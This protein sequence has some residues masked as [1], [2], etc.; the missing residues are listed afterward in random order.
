VYFDLDVPKGDYRIEFFANPSAADP[1]GN[2]E[3][4]VFA[5]ATT[6]AHTGSGIESFG[7]TFPGTVGDISTS[8]TTE[9]LAGP[10]YGASSEF[11]GAFTA[12]DICP[13][14]VVTTTADSGVSS[15]L[16]SCIIWANGNVGADTLSVPAGT[17]NLSIAGT[18]EDAATTGDLDITDDL[19]LNGA[20][21]ISTIIDGNA[22]DRVFDFIAG[23]SELSGV[24]VRN[25]NTNS[26]GGGILNHSNLTLSDLA[27]SGNNAN[28]GGGI[29]NLLGASLT[30]SN[31]TINGNTATSV[32]GG[33]RDRGTSVLTNVTLSG[34][35]ASEGGGMEIRDGTTM[36]NVTITANSAAD[37]GGLQTQGA[38][39][40]S[41]VKN[42]IIA[43]NLIG[44]DCLGGLTVLGNNLDSDG[45]CGFGL[46]D[47]APLL[48]PL[49][50]NGGPTFTHALL[51][52]SPAIDSGDS[53]V[54][55]SPTNDR[56]QR[57]F[58]R[59][60]GA[61]CDIGAYEADSAPPT[62]TKAAFWT[63][64]T[65]IP[66]GSTIPSGVEFKY[67]LYVNNLSVAQ[68]DVT[69]RD[70]LDPAFQYQVGTIQV[71]NSVAECAGAVCTPAEEQTIFTAVD[72]AAF[73]T[74][75]ADGDV[76]G[77]TGASTSVDAGNG[78]VANLQL[79]INGGAVWAILFSAKMP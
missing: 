34:N 72:G 63:D 29:D 11:S 17:Y 42:T 15:T 33:F 32:G 56:D 60:V 26:T 57:G 40:L 47:P 55:I 77:Y 48:G 61:S 27:V 69:V 21:P 70:V 41:S 8:T 13:G 6:I 76:A 73:V 53:S 35:A 31:S 28:Q 65:P 19:I 14:G 62:L 9:E 39:S 7:H 25:G 71:D 16:R 74:D 58:P 4:E 64:G 59:P 44:V 67:L 3:G 37:G 22:L 54:C 12:V 51:T 20:G 50:D 24:T 23:T 52:G 38:P 79:D 66:T 10:A 75:A 49:Q 30:L 1:S 78:N 18:A 45:S 36:L 46:T 43:A 2:G 68:A 5:G